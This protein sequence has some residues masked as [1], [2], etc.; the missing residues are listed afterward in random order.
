MEC[1][2]LYKKIDDGLQTENEHAHKDVLAHIEVPS[3]SKIGEL[4]LKLIET[5][6]R[7]VQSNHYR[8]EPHIQYVAHDNQLCLGKHGV[9]ALVKANAIDQG[10]DYQAENGV[11]Y[12]Y[13][14]CQDDVKVSAEFVVE[15]VIKAYLVFLYLVDVVIGCNIL[16][17]FDTILSEVHVGCGPAAVLL[18]I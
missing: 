16:I 12:D 1:Q 2:I 15:N 7:Q 9:C 5:I 11:N 13:C 14:D 17:V 10:L 6:L 3:L 18:I 8:Q 4:A